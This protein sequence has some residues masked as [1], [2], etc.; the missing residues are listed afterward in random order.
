LGN[1][2]DW[3]WNCTT[4]TGASASGWDMGKTLGDDVREQLDAG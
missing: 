1:R 2:V 4:E 3:Q